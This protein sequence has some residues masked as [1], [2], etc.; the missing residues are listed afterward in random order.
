MCGTIERIR[1]FPSKGTAGE[2]L[3]EGRLI[4]NSGLEGDFHALGGDRQL[5]LLFAE[6]R[7]RVA[8]QKERGLCLSRFREN[9]SVRGM[10][11][12]G[13]KA[14]TRLEAGEAIL[15]ISGETKYCHEECSLFQK[16]KGC[17]LAGMNLFARVIKSGVIRN[18]NR[19]C[20][21]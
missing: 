11:P 18:G 2:E 20:A 9:I 8:E 12:D 3:T 1:V 10:A 4:E 14:G 19:I 21:E 6:T 5:S 17:V 15:E 13:L 16:G 7:D